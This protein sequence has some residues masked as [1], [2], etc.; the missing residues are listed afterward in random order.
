L[1]L[2]PKVGL[3]FELAVPARY[4]GTREGDFMLPPLMLLSVFRILPPEEGLD[5]IGLAAIDG[6]PPCFV[7]CAYACSVGNKSE[8]KKL[9][10]V[11]TPDQT[12]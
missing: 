9:T 8:L 1:L 3:L 12:H 4:W 5:A 10:K 2:F 11:K 7:L 6:P